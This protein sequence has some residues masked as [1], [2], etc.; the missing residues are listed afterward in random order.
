MRSVLLIVVLGATLTG[1]GSDGP[2][3]DEPTGR[4]AGV[5]LLGPMCPV[6]N[7]ASPCPDQP[8]ADT[9]VEAHAAGG[10]VAAEDV[11]D[12][13][14]RFELLLPA[15]DYTLTASLDDPIRVAAPVAVHVVA[16]E[17]AQVT[18]SV[19]SGIR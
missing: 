18:V 15:G 12:D 13:D 3:A 11:S 16:G 10:D 17:E 7:A 19:D 8:L 14:G 6:E 9:V 4:V 1:C 5:V 2:S